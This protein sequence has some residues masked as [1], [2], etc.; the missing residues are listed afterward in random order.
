MNHRHIQPVIDALGSLERAGCALLG[1]EALQPSLDAKL[2]EGVRMA[3]LGA[4]SLF[5]AL[6]AARQ[7]GK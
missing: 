6:I 7:E 2:L 1:A 3:T 4:R 5:A